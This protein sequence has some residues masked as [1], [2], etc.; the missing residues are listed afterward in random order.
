M[1]SQR[2]CDSG[3]PRTGP[4]RPRGGCTVNGRSAVKG[5]LLLLLGICGVPSSAPAGVLRADLPDSLN[6]GDRYLFYLHGQII[7]DQ[8]TRPR[9][10][11]FGVYEYE[12]ILLELARH[13]LVVIS[14]AR[15]MGTDV[16]AYA[17][18]IARQVRHLMEAGV[19]ADR[20]TVAGHSKGGA[21]AIVTSAI[22]ANPGVAYV[23]LASC[24]PWLDR[25]DAPR[26]CGQILSIVEASDDLVGSC[27][28]AFTRALEG[29]R[30]Q[31][32]RLYLGGGH[33]A[34][35]AP[36]PAWIEPLTR[37]AGREP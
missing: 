11:R 28:P 6:V 20:I 34:F 37:W 2:G 3:V 9:H 14:E 13:D 10:P 32:L 36:R 12:A 26:L 17:E 8:G 35:Y 22:L 5:A 21:I 30:V 23:L 31:E 24:G 29:S 18:K 4:W 33:G 25:A 1:T 19:P 7:E 27:D 15:P 16:G